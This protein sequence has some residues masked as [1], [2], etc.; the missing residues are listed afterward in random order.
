MKRSFFFRVVPGIILFACSPASLCPGVVDIPPIVRG[1]PGWVPYLAGTGAVVFLLIL[2]TWFGNAR[3]RRLL[4]RRTAELKKIEERLAYLSLA[5]ESLGEMII[6]TD[7]DHVITYA[8]AAVQQALGYSAEEM[9]GRPAADF[10]EGISGNPP[11]LREHIRGAGETPV[12]RGEIYN[13]RKDGDLIRVYL[14]LA[15]LR[16]PAGKVIGTVGVSMDV[17]E[18]RALEEQLRHSQKLEAVGTLAGGIAHDFNNLLAGALGYLCLIKKEIPRQGELFTEIEAVER[19]LWRG[20]DLTG[21]LLAFSRKGVCR[22]EPLDIN[23]AVKEVLTMIGRTGGKNIDLVTAFAPDARSVL[24][25]RGQVNQVVMNLC[26]NGCEA[27]P[28]GGTLAVA[29]R[30]IGPGDR[31]FRLRP[32]LRKRDYVLISFSD[33]G[34]GIKGE[35]RERIFEP[36][37]ST[38]EDKTGVGLGLSVANGIVERHGGCIE[39]ESEEGRGSVFRVYLPA[40][41]REEILSPPPTGSLPG[42]AE[43]ILAVDDNPDFRTVITDTLGNL[44]YTVIPAVN[45]REALRILKK[46]GDAV[47][48]VL[49]D[50]IMKGLS[51][52]ETFRR[53]REMKPELPVLICTGSALDGIIGRLGG[54]RRCGFIQKPFPHRRLAEKI[55]DLLDGS[56]AEIR[57][58]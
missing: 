37:F 26:L 24:G 3:L 38:K 53:M 23:L 57:T 7:L 30:N 17:T 34:G 51:G 56:L 32:D 11:S 29:T 52:P 43:T 20:S 6:V 36:F 10:F 39:V 54:E 33:T 1:Y 58:A 18:Y 50:M 40:T 42:G 48:L 8:N 31:I 28:D 13:R 55:R 21:A 22:P 41:D 47:D 14:T 15:W 49:L 5:V 27:M 25:D 9:I 19:L 44:G 2:L 4:I 12:W 46:K 45:G 35:L 16:D